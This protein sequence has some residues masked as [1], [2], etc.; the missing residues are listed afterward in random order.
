MQFKEEIILH[1]STNA[2]STCAQKEHLVS[3]IHSVHQ[4]H[5]NGGETV[6]DSSPDHQGALVYGI[7]RLV[8]Q[9]M[10]TDEVYSLVRKGFG[11]VEIRGESSSRTLNNKNKMRYQ[12]RINNDKQIW[13]SNTHSAWPRVRDFASVRCP[14]VVVAMFV[15]ERPIENISDV[16]HWVNTHR[17]AFKHWAGEIRHRNSIDIMTKLTKDIQYKL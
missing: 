15:R 12:W 9:R 11:G 17:R 14:L 1:A 8:H 10:G 3:S 2:E 4:I 5:S 16:R 7:Y 13:F 6:V